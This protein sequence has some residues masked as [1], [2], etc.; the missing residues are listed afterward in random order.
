MQIEST[1]GP[2]HELDVQGLAIAVFKDERAD[3]GFLR[4]LDALTGGAIKSVID[5]EELKGKEAETVYLHLIGNSEIRAQRLLLIGV[6]ERGEYST[7]QASQFAGT[8]VRA[9]RGKSVKS[10]AIVPRL[11]GNPEEIASVVIEGAFMSLFDPDKYRTVDKEERQIERLVVVMAGADET[12]LKR[13][14]ERGRIIGESVNFTRDLANEPGANMT[15]TIMSERA[16]EVAGEFGLS[17]DVLDEA[18]M[19][20]EGMGSLLSVARGSDEP[21]K[22]IVLKYTPSNGAEESAGLLAFVGKGVT[23]DSGGISLKPGE[24]ME[25][26]KYDM[27]GGATVIGAMRAIGQLKPPIPVLGVI[28]CAENLP[29]GKATKPGDV[30][31]A[32]TGKTIEVIN[33]DAEGR[34]ILADAI[35]YAKKLGATKIIDMATLTGAVSIALGDVHAAVLGTD[36][37]LIDEI[38]AAGKEAGEKFWQ[39]PLDKEYSKQIKSDIADIK[40]VG[41][42]KAGTITAAAFL[43]EFADGVSWAHL[44]IAGTAW[45]DEAKPYRS[46][47]PTGIAVRTLLRIVSRA[48]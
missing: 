4:D 24:N 28:P 26:M 13:G 47:G 18:R 12:G 21:G 40:N 9:L 7:T 44:D 36:Q 45:G 25:L 10:I 43:K 1:N 15:P 8:A 41:G 34:L 6:G 23:F 5:S 17:V 22:L 27:T 16:R 19:E 37:E 32:M 42:R 46:K 31:R 29:S 39:L 14:V 33:T 11:E 38:I 35:A 2:Y 48:S 20:Q 3:E 30:V